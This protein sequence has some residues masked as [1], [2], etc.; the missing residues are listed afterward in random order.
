MPRCSPNGSCASST[1]RNG[2]ARSSVL[3]EIAKDP[4]VDS[5]RILHDASGFREARPRCDH[6]LPEVERAQPA[7]TIG[8]EQQPRPVADREAGLAG[9]RR[10]GTP[11]RVRGPFRRAS[12][13]SLSERRR[14]P[15]LG[16]PPQR[17]P[18]TAAHG[19]QFGGPI[20]RSSTVPSTGR[21]PLQY[22]SFR[23]TGEN[24]DE[25]QD[26]AVRS[27]ACPYGPGVEISH[28]TGTGGRAGGK[29]SA[30]DAPGQPGAVRSER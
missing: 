27:L 29:P 25:V 9:T 8:H 10:P 16:H 3:T 30:V 20:H 13:P 28:A 1:Q 26:F 18:P 6:C 24:F 7:R 15:S 11:R 21:N 17:D 19:P 14:R 2:S 23:Q 5:R 12:R 4:S 22:K